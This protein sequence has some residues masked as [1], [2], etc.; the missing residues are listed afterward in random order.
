MESKILK[1]AIEISNQRDL[2]SLEYSLVTTMA[3]LVPATEFSVLK[4]IH[5]N[6]RDK[7]EMALCLNVMI[8]AHGNNNYAW[9]EDSKIITVDPDVKNSLVSTA[10]S[11]HITS[12]GLTQILSPITCD[13]KI[14]GAF[15]IKG[16]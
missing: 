4:T 11:T 14:I 10:T 6:I 7:L 3:E 16:N 13:G 1:S 8:D 9:A 2:D 5:E 15:S 12:E